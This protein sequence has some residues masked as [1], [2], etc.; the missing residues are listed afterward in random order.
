MAVTQSAVLVGSSFGT[1]TSFSVASASLTASKLY[2]ISIYNNSAG[3]G[4]N[5]A[6]SSVT[7]AGVSFTKI[8]DVVAETSWGRLSVWRAM[9]G[10]NASGTGTI[11][12]ANAQDA[13]IWSLSEFSGIDTTGTNGS[14]AIVQSAVT[15]PTTNTT[16]MNV[17][18]AAFGS[19]G[20]AAYSACTAAYGTAQNPTFTP[21]TNWSEIHDREQDASGWTIA[22]HTIWRDNGND[23]TPTHTI[24]ITSL[25]SGAVGVEIKAAAGGPTTYSYTGSGSIGVGGAGTP[26]RTF[27]PSASGGVSLAGAGTVKRAFAPVSS[28]GVTLSGEAT[29]RRAFTP[30][31]SGGFTFSGTAPVKATYAPPAGGN[32]AIGGAALAT[33]SLKV[34]GQGGFALNG[35]ASV[36]RTFAYEGSGNIAL[37]GAANT[38]TGGATTY[39]YTGSGNIAITGAA[40]VK[41][42]IIAA[43]AGQVTFGG[44][45]VVKL[46]VTPPVGGQL[47]FGGEAAI[48][49]A[50]AY[51][52]AP[53]A[54][55]IA[56]QASYEF[57]PTGPRIY[58]YTGSGNISLTG[59]AYTQM[60]Q[61][62]VD[63][64]G[65]LGGLIQK[66]WRE[67]PKTIEIVKHVYAYHGSGSIRVGSSAKTELRAVQVIRHY[68]TTSS[69]II[70]IRG[71]ANCEFHP[72]ISS[73][74][75]QQTK[76][77]A[78]ALAAS[79]RNF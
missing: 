3:S 25:S 45:A 56:G 74:K 48:A 65:F 38:S 30:G 42:T 31:V 76:V 75:R 9:P 72:K 39:T 2:L 15:G 40:G 1:A 34:P 37:G 62:S 20:N 8:N 46:T 21:E 69:A 60:I 53:T 54:I 26:K 71:A 4:N 79:A 47:V 19:T 35:A 44:N 67:K 59:S 77:F 57:V 43:A 51:Q 55:A 52:P 11:S 58:Q 32:L 64:G 33:F 18:L 23:T 16:S 6:P 70:K 73:E 36:S 49:R 24:A 17:T 28:G 14:G 7:I 12:F 29:I 13:A 41:R 22:L 27:A 61:A 10:S 78:L 63:G 50:F 5:A 68:S 66:T